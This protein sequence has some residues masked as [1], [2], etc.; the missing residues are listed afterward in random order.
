M[1]SFEPFERLPNLI[2]PRQILKTLLCMQVEIQNSQ[3][4]SVW[5]AP[6]WPYCRSTWRADWR[7]W[8]EWWWSA[9]PVLRTKRLVKSFETFEICALWVGRGQESYHE[10]VLLRRLPVLP[11]PQNSE[12]S[13]GDRTG[14]VTLRQ[15]KDLPASAQLLVRTI[16][17]FHPN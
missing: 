17:G 8:R 10:E 2:I 13:G 6:C 11:L 7:C 12:L 9:L 15:M 3:R 14:Y 4:K 5:C 1:E 16:T